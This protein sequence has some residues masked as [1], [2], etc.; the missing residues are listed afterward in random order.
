MF[1]KKV[2]QSVS[3]RIYVNHYCLSKMQVTAMSFSTLLQSW[4]KN[5]TTCCTIL[6]GIPRI[7]SQIHCFK[8]SIWEGH[9]CI[10]C[11]VA[12]EKID[13]YCKIRLAGVSGDVPKMRNEF[14]WKHCPDNLHRN[15]LYEQFLLTS[16]C[17]KLVGMAMPLCWQ[18][19]FSDLKCNHPFM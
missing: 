10:H 16:L 14:V 15:V 4:Y 19:W 17:M 2:I 12:I 13:W 1:L 18:A 7:C 8:A 5:V 6:F 11:F 3:I 9:F